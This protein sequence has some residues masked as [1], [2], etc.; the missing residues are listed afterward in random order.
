MSE[1]KDRNKRLKIELPIILLIFL[2]LLALFYKTLQLRPDPQ[3][4][5]LIILVPA[6]IITF[7]HI[8][9][10]IKPGLLPSPGS[11]SDFLDVDSGEQ[12]ADTDPRDKIRDSLFIVGW[13]ALLVIAIFLVGFIPGTVLFAFTFLYFIGGQSWQRSFLVSIIL[14]GMI[15]LIFIELINIRSIDP[16]IPLGLP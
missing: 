11:F 7:I 9:N 8:I 16:I 14:A 1:N 15:Y 12:D 5:P 2:Y 4:V 6:T 10:L 3:L 13:F